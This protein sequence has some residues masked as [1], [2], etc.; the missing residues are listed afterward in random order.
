MV[1][2]SGRIVQMQCN[3]VVETN[4]IISMYYEASFWI[5]DIDEMKGKKWEAR[6]ITK[7][8]FVAQSASIH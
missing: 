5:M 6:Y 7:K 8:L 4:I 1:E 2:H 3:A